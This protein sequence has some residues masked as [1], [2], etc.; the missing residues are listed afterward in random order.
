ME[1][2]FKTILIFYDAY[3]LL[4]AM[5]FRS[6]S[7]GQVF[8]FVVSWLY[9]TLQSVP[10]SKWDGIFL[11]YDNMCQLARLRAGRK[12]LPLPSP[13]DQMWLVIQKVID[14]LHLWTTRTQSAI[15][16]TIQIKFL[17]F[18]R[19]ST[20]KTLK[21][22]SRLLSGSAASRRLCALCQKHTI[23]SSCTVKWHDVTGTVQNV[24]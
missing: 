21:P 11:A 13:Y 14:S 2:W 1:N 23:C 19:T 6:E 4:F 15:Q 12:P 3:N 24:I 18:T 17:T 16:N 8:L 9:H 22:G 10:R 7:L 20:T 5:C